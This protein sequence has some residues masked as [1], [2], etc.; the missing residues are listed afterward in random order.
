MHAAFWKAIQRG[1][2]P[3]AALLAAKQ[4]YSAGIPHGG[5]TNVM[6]LATELK[7][8]RQYACLGLGW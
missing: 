1:M 6:N 7:T 8:L 5:L 3:A 2:A 4:E